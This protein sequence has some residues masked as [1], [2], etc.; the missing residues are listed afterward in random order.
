MS[1]SQWSLSPSSQDSSSAEQASYQLSSFI[2]G[3][4]HLKVVCC[5]VSHLSSGNTA[6]DALDGADGVPTFVLSSFFLSQTT[7]SFS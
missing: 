5:C 1:P 2:A 7:F 6:V 3:A 4:F